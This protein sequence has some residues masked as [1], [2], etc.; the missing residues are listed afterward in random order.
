MQAGIAGLWNNAGWNRKWQI[1]RSLDDGR[2]R[3]L[4]MD[5]C[6][7]PAEPLLPTRGLP[8]QGRGE[9]NYSGHLLTR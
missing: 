2:M 5:P 4:D 8:V 9:I 7:V 3:N 6:A 1:S